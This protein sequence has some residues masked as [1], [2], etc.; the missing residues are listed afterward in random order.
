MYCSQQINSVTE[1]YR[2]LRKCSKN[3]Y[4]LLDGLPGC[5]CDDKPHNHI[6]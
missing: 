5:G 2:E 6:N 4:V 1:S 3:A